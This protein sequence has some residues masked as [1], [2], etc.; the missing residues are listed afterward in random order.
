MPGGAAAAAAEETP[1]PKEKY[2][3][4][5]KSK[6]ARGGGNKPPTGSGDRD[7]SPSTA[8]T[9]SWIKLRPG[10]KSIREWMKIDQA[11]PELDWNRAREAD[12]RDE[13][14]LGEPCFG[15]HDTLNPLA[16][17]ANQFQVQ[18]K[19]V[20]CRLLM[21]YVPKRGATGEFRKAG[22]LGKTVGQLNI[23]EITKERPPK[24]EHSRATSKDKH[25]EAPPVPSWS[26]S[27]EDSSFQKE[28]TS[29]E[30]ETPWVDTGKKRATTPGNPQG[31]AGSHAPGVQAAV[32]DLMRDSTKRPAAAPSR[33]RTP[34]TSPQGGGPED[35]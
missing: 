31:A 6:P 14:F 22:P 34:K 27:E 32:N 19:C 13:R 8:S 12:E 28:G 26:E 16:R 17:N 11:N 18:Y 2:E 35:V 33:R 30:E 4:G 25:P 7:A 1:V 24:K 9:G 5:Q 23:R 21:L 3:K 10:R 29:D 15:D 20:R